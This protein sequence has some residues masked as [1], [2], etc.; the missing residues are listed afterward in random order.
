MSNEEPETQDT[1]K[2]EAIKNIFSELN[3]TITELRKYVTEQS[4]EI[5]QKNAQ[6]AE[7]EKKLK[8]KS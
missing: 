2:S 8:G 4:K 3:K 7:L 6:I 5:A 1:H